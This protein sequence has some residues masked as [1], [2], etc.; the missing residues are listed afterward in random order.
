MGFFETSDDL[1]EADE[2]VGAWGVVG[3]IEEEVGFLVTHC[4]EA[5]TELET[6]C[7]KSR[8]IRVLKFKSRGVATLVTR[9]AIYIFILARRS[10]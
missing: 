4:M 10:A 9:L 5:S 6:E 2:A 8:G 7:I 1:A 3:A